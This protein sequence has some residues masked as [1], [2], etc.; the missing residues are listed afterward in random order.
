MSYRQYNKQTFDPF[1]KDCQGIEIL[2]RLSQNSQTYKIK[3][4]SIFKSQESIYD[5]KNLCLQEVF[6]TVLSMN[7][8]DLQVHQ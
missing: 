4:F 2:R 1:A 6:L 7:H 8:Q 5:T 3:L